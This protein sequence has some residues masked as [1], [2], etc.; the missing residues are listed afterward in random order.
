MAMGDLAWSADGSRRFGT[1]LLDQFSEGEGGYV[2]GPERALMSALLFDGVINCMNYAG[3][4]GKSAQ[5]RF[6]EAFS[7][8]MRAGNEY[9]FSFE[10]VCDCLGV[11]ADSLRMGLINVINSRRGDQ[12]KSRRNF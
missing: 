9:I 8:I 4:G 2:T 6:R 11:N 1:V 3:C 5:A 12:K 7:W 10:N